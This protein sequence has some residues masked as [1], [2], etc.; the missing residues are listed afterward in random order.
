[1]NQILKMQSEENS[2]ENPGR[3]D[4]QGCQTKN[5]GKKKEKEPHEMGPGR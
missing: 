5:F 3:K 2:A 4:S 1:M